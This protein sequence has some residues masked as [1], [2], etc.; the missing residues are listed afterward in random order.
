MA[1]LG[2]TDIMARDASAVGCVVRLRL[3]ATTDLHAHLFPFNYYTDR[4]DDSV[5]LARAASLIA[6]LRDDVDTSLLFDN[7]DTLQGAPLGDA[8]LSEIVPQGRPHPMVAAMNALGY[9]AAT[10]GNHD[11]D[12]GL[13]FLQSALSAASYPVLLANAVRADGSEFLPG[14]VVLQR[15]CPDADGR[16]HRLNIGVIGVAPPQ[17]AQ[18]SRTLL[19]GALVLSDMQEA[20]RREV[21]TLEG[22]GADLILVLAHSGL[23]VPEA[24]VGAENA[25]L[26]ISRIAGVDAVIAGHSHDLFAGAADEGAP[27]VQPGFWGSHVGVI[28][29]TLLGTPPEDDPDALPSDW[30]RVDSETR[31]VPISGAGSAARM[32]FRRSLRKV[33]RLRAQMAQ[34]HRLT[35]KFTGRPLGTTSKPIETYFSLLAPCRAMTILADASRKAARQALS[36]RADL[37]DLPLV[38]AVAPFKAGGRGGPENYTD[39]P[40]GRLQLRHAADLYVYPNRLAILRAT[41]QQVRDWLERAASAYHRIDPTLAADG[42]Q[43]LIDHAFPAYNF[44]VFDGLS[45]AFDLSAEARTNAEGDEICEG[46]GRVRDLCLADGTPLAATDE[47]LVV[48]NSYRASGG[49]HFPAAATATT[50]LTSSDTVRDAVAR[51]IAETPDLGAVTLRT[52]WRFVPMGGC[53]VLVETGPGALAYPDR[54]AE[55]GLEPDGPAETGFHRFRWSL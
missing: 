29:L 35:R 49:G 18:W 46:P 45:Y 11:F 36:D 50:V 17:I 13:P 43:A 19:N 55:L 22:K 5:G 41:G 12:Y 39:I 44:D 4:R 37:A 54:I 3:I 53:P 7:G 24:E 30:H 32:A 34:D 6:G 14:H 16:M 20:V 42:P 2:K 15:D 47:V 28:D 8:A 33:P 10:L 1:H 52:P 26:A 48:T 27:I 51:H 21:A 38:A 25:A 31:V 40:A 23:G 9:D